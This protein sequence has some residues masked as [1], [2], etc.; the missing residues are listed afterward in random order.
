MTTIS[1]EVNGE[2]LEAVMREIEA[3]PENHQ[4]QVWATSDPRALPK[5]NTCGSAY[6]YAGQTLVEAGYTLRFHRSGAIEI[7]EPN[8]DAVPPWHSIPTLASELL[9]LTT[10]DPNWRF[11]LFASS[12]TREDLR[13]MVEA[14]KARMTV[15]EFFAKHGRPEDGWGAGAGG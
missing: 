11:A 9:G 7:F 8:G 5:G 15:D 6:C 4:Q 13:L 10:L 1:T 2:L 14:I 12:N 3:H